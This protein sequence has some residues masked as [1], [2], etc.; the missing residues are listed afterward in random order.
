MFLENVC[1]SDPV[2]PNQEKKGWGSDFT[3]PEPR[4]STIWAGSLLLLK[5]NC[6]FFTI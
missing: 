4:T 2:V 5:A 1:G 3:H 6:L